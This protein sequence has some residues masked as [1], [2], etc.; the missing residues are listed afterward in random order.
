MRAIL[1][2]VFLFVGMISYSQQLQLHYD[3]RH[4]INPEQNSKNFFSLTFDYYKVNAKE[5][6]DFLIQMQTDFTGEAQNPGQMYIQLT[7]YFR[8]WKP[9]INLSLGYAGGFGIAPPSYGYYIANSYTLGIS[10]P[11]SW[12]SLFCSLS[13]GYKYNAFT[14]PSN[15][16]FLSAYFWSGLFNYKASISGSLSLGTQN[17][18]IGDGST[19]N[20]DGKKITFWFGPQF[21]IKVIDKWSAGTK[22]NVY[23]NGESIHFYPT[24]GIKYDF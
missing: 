24:L 6:G 14:A 2:S 17:R 22:L 13:G 8:Y 3:I 15:D 16:A 1:L 23:S 10:Y 21:W 19:D 12:K 7:K 18:N 11:I 5:K 4:T 20:L 9:K